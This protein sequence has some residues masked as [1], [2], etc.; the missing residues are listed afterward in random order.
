MIRLHFDPQDFFPEIFT[1][2]DLGLADKGHSRVLP[3]QRSTAK[4][5]FGNVFL[6]CVK[7]PVDDNS[8]DC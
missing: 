7:K 6:K 5:R 8:K 1:L 3:N 4:Y 2:R